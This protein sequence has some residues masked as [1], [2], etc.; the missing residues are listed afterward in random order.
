MEQQHRLDRPRGSDSRGCPGLNAARPAADEAIFDGS[1]ARAL[2]VSLAGVN[3]S[4]RSLSFSN[5]SYTLTGGSLVLQ[6]SSG[7]ATISVAGGMQTMDASVDLLLESGLAIAP[8]AGAA[9][10]IAGNISGSGALSLTGPGT[11]ILS[12]SDN[13]F[14]GGVS[15]VAGTLIVTDTRALRDG[16]TLVVGDSAAF[17]ASLIPSQGAGTEGGEQPTATVPEPN[18]LTLLIAG[19]A[20][21]AVYRAS[22]KDRR[23]QT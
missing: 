20:L 17:F 21:L 9:M 5:S 15:V 6:S 7:S 22:F 1:G 16:E 8:Q 23:M 3:P 11:L 18:P 19:F 13:S 12:S 4:L 2:T 10:T 14:S